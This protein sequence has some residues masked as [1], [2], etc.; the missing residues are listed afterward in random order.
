M[1]ESSFVSG[2][3]GESREKIHGSYPSMPDSSS[4]TKKPK[5]WTSRR[6]KICKP[7]SRSCFRRKLDYIP[8]STRNC[9]DGPLVRDTSPSRG[10]VESFEFVERRRSKILRMEEAK[11]TGKSSSFFVSV[12]TAKGERPMLGRI[13]IPWRQRGLAWLQVQGA[14]VTIFGWNQ[15]HPT[16]GDFYSTEPSHRYCP[17]RLQTGCAWSRDGC[18]FHYLDSVRLDLRVSILRIS[19]YP[20]TFE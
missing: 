8:V 12:D 14:K 19:S 6:T 10:S 18:N 11:C 15:P 9:L 7:G 2:F 3:H 17:C 4:C 16:G 1:R 13:F 5:S 20:K